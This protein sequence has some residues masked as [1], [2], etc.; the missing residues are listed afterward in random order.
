MF[1]PTHLLVS[2]SRQTPVH[3]LPSQSGF[4]L[5]TETEWQQHRQPAFELHSKRGFFCQ[6][7]PVIGYSLQPLETQQS[8]SV[9]VPAAISS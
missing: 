3:L 6:G 7:I 1:S 9:S 5:F 8:L 2:R 4:F